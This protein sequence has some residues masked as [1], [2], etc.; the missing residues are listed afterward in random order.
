ME[1]GFYCDAGKLSHN[2]NVLSQ[3]STNI[4]V[5]WWSYVLVLNEQFHGLN[6]PHTHTHTHI[7]KMVNLNSRL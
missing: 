7:K 5:L 3:K 6:D 2:Y 1:T 4:C